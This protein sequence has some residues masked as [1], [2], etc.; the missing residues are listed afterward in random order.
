M[1][2]ILF[3][4]HFNH[5]D[6]H[7]ARGFVKKIS[8]IFFDYDPYFL[9]RR[10]VNTLKDLNFKHESSPLD[11]I[12]IDSSFY[13]ENDDIYCNTWYGSGDRKYLQQYGISFDCLYSIF[14]DFVKN[15]FDT[16]LYDIDPCIENWFPNINYSKFN[17]ENINNW[18]EKNIKPKILIVNGHSRSGQSDNFI[19]TEMI[20]YFSR[21]NNYN[22][23]Y[24]NIEHDEFSKEYKPLEKENVFF[25]NDIIGNLDFD[26]NEIAYLST[27]CDIIIGRAT[28]AFT[29]AFNYDNLFKRKI[30]MISLS[31][32][33][34]EQSNKFWISSKFKDKINYN[35]EVIK[36]NRKVHIMDTLGGLIDKLSICNLKMWNA[37]DI[38]YQIRK[39]SFEEYKEKY[40]SSEEGAR[41]LWKIFQKAC[42][43]NLQ[44]NVLIDEID[45][46]IIEI[47]DSSKNGEDLDNG[48]FIQRKHKSY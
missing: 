1:K 6:L 28:G 35:S 16:S 3:Y 19:M 30:K 47:I 15:T 44:R 5:G 24:T 48:K 12:S 31:N 21:L 38:L 25:T 9:H 34:T 36:R 13:K 7:I 39:M 40:F 26:L 27:H 23:I 10:N 4:N 41:K 22:I 43:L 11:S 14:D 2:K 20:N 42:D 45:K 46:R 32:L 8:D 17:I 37:Q 33:M 29:F 18:L